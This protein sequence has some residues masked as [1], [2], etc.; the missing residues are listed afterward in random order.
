MPPDGSAT[1]L[2]TLDEARA[3]QV[4]IDWSAFEPV[5]PAFTG[6][7][8]LDDISLKELAG[9]HRLDPILPGVGPR[10]FVP[11]DPRR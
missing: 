4:P 3:N 8:V 11:E 2:V 9:L 5:E 10:R 7:R 1:K 6:V